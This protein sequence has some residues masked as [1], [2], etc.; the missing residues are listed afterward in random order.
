MGRRIRPMNAFG[1]LYL[2]AVSSIDAT[3]KQI[4]GSVVGSS[5]PRLLTVVRDKRRGNSN[6]QKAANLLSEITMG[7]RRDLTP[8]QRLL[9]SSLESL[10]FLFFHLLSRFIEERPHPSLGF[11][12][13]GL[14]SDACVLSWKM[15]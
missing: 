14:K 13:G 1:I 12:A 7:S 6:N 2:F 5:H 10:S 3:T 9:C 4:R 8:D 11:R 15:R